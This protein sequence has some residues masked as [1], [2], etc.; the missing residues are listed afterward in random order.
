MF[1]IMNK[2]GF[3]KFK[4]CFKSPEIASMAKSANA[5]S[6]VVENIGMSV[7]FDVV[8]I[9]IE[10]IPACEDDIYSLL[11]SVSNLD[12]KEVQEMGMSAFIE[13]IVDFIKKPEFKDFF[14]VVSR[15]FKSEI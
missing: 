9:V 4:D 15:L 7:L 8:G 1:K 14:K 12:K 13:M 10:N 5:D 11:A 2:I 3:R 6:E